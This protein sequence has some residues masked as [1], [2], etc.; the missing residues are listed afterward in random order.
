MGCLLYI[1]YPLYLRKYINQ[2]DLQLVA[3]KP[4]TN[5]QPTV[6]GIFF[7]SILHLT[8]EIMPMYE[9]DIKFQL[10]EWNTN[11]LVTRAQ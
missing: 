7:S 11:N 4:Y 5:K 1:P 2:I 3:I 10:F 9:H 6:E 8:I